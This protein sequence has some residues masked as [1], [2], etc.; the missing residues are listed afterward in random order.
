LEG[1][2]HKKPEGG[3]GRKIK[4]ENNVFR[5][6]RHG[7]RIGRGNARE[8]GAKKTVCKGNC[9]ARTEKKR[10]KSEEEKDTYTVTCSNTKSQVGRRN[11]PSSSNRKLTKKGILAKKK[12]V[13]PAPKEKTVKLS[14]NRGGGEEL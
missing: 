1:K 9:K 7:R 5:V 8:H 10:G 11:P 12:K 4:E 14:T 3:K 6:A 2:T 13:S